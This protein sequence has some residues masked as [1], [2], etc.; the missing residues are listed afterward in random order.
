MQNIQNPKL[1]S[2]GIRNIQPARIAKPQKIFLSDVS[3][4]LSQHLEK[5]FHELEY[6]GVKGLIKMLSIVQASL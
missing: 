3:D 4:Y 5:N 1:D 6:C 2:L